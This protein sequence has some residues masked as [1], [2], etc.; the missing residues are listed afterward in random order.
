MLKSRVVY[1][2]AKRDSIAPVMCG[3]ALRYEQEL[4]QD[5]IAMRRLIMDRYLCVRRRGGIGSVDVHD[6]T[7]T[8]WWLR[9]TSHLLCIGAT[10]T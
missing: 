8:G 2:A 7:V 4:Y 10:G 5:E 3:S 9:A 1:F 6:C